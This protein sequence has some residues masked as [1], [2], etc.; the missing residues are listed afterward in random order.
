MKTIK[1][2]SSRWPVHNG[3]LF[4]LCAEECGLLRPEWKSLS[5]VLQSSQGHTRGLRAALQQ[6]GFASNWNSVCWGWGEER[7][8]YRLR[9]QT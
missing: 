7:G 1:C 9:A 8:S 2:F 5:F 3:C 6:G 4:S